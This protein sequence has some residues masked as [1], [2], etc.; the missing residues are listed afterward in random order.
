MLLRTLDKNQPVTCQDCKKVVIL[1]PDTIT[2]PD[3]ALA[4]LENSERIELPSTQSFGVKKLVEELITLSPDV[5][6]KHRV[7]DTVMALW[8]AET[9]A[10]E[11]VQSISNRSYY[12]KASGFLSERDKE[13]RFVVNLDEVQQEKQN[14]AVWV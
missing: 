5:K 12:G 7:Q 11:V 10:R 8:F 13:R 14:R 2:V 4:N 1:D 3:H 9:R 6:T